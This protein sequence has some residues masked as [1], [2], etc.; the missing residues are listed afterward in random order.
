MRLPRYRHRDREA[1]DR[2]GNRYLLSF[3]AEHNPTAIFVLSLADLAAM[4]DLNDGYATL[5]SSDFLTSELLSAR[6]LHLNVI[7]RPP[8]G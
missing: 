1:F 7:R 6:R 4:A 8:V 3:H 5:L 2:V